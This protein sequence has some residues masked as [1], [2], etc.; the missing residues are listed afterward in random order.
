LFRIFATREEW[1]QAL[2]D[3]QLTATVP[4]IVAAKYA[5]TMR[6]YR[7]AWWEPDV[8]KA[9]E[10]AAFAALELAL[11]DRFGRRR[12]A[13]QLQGLVRDHGLS[14]RDLPSIVAVRGT[15]V[16]RLTGESTPSLAQLRNA[17]AHGDPF[18]SGPLVGLIPLIRDLIDF[19]YTRRPL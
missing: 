3:L 5:R 1:L 19:A 16:A 12:L 11:R 8:I 6:L 17:L 15:A 9:A 2:E 4:E 14:D 13:L 7:L 18:E 10:V